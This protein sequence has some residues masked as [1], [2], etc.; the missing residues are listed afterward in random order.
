MGIEFHGDLAIYYAIDDNEARFA[1]AHRRLR[2]SFPRA[3]LT[4]LSKGRA[5]R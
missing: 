2:L 1:F 4:I 5:L 3:R